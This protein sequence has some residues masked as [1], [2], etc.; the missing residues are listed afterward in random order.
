MGDGLIYFSK[1]L[2][3][4]C[5]LYKDLFNYKDDVSSYI[6]ARDKGIEEGYNFAKNEIKSLID[7][8]NKAGFHN[9]P[10]FKKVIED[11]TKSYELN[12]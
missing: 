1:E 11:V 12:K 3:Q 8:V 9:E 2:N 4:A 10:V 7:K 5:E 6:S